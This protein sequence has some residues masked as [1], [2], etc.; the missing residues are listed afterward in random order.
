MGKWLKKNGFDYFLMKQNPN[1]YSGD[2]ANNKLVS[3]SRF[4]FSTDPDTGQ[5]TGTKPEGNS[6]AEVVQQLKEAV[7]YCV[8][9]F[10]AKHGDSKKPNIVIDASKKGQFHV[11]ADNY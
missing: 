2:I 8:A 9:E 10:R 11:H 6:E 7:D 4:K 3:Q 5:R 1:N